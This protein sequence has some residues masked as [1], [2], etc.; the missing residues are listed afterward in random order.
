MT[1][2]GGSCHVRNGQLESVNGMAVFAVQRPSYALIERFD[3][4]L[5]LLGHMAHDGVDHLALVVSL[6]ALDNVLGRNTSF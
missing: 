6:L 4:R 2:M 1:Q 3:W 5:G